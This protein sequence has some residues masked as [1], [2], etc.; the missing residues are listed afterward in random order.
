MISIAQLQAKLVSDPFRTTEYQCQTDI[1]LYSSPT[2]D[3]LVTQA[4]SGRQLRLIAIPQDLA[5]DFDDSAIEVCLCEDDYS[6]WLRIEDLVQLK[7][8]D[9]AYQAIALSADDIR[10]RLPQ[11]IDFTYQAMNQPN[12]Y[13]WGGT[14]GPNYDCSGLMQTAFAA[15]GIWLPRDAYQQEA[16]VQALPIEALRPGDLIFFGQTERANHVGLYLGEGN[17]IHS[18]GK[19]QGRNSIGIDSL[20][21]PTSAISQ[22]YYKQLRS[23]GRVITS[24]QPQELRAM[25]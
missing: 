1:N 23:Y 12:Q 11:V 17:Y 7:I 8:A 19:D 6:G 18:S 21:G 9:T 10:A 2:S 5:G 13:L 15:T 14:V 16:F 3:S 20:S 4:T 22:R 25:P 24:Y